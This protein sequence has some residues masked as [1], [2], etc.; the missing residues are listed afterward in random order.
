MEETAQLKQRKSRNVDSDSD[1]PLPVPIDCESDSDD[2]PPVPI[3]CEAKKKLILESKKVGMLERYV[4]YVVLK[5]LNHGRFDMLQQARRFSGLRHARF[6]DFK[7][8]VETKSDLPLK[9]WGDKCISATLNYER[10]VMR[11]PNRNPYVLYL[12]ST[13]QNNWLKQALC[14]SLGDW[15]IPVFSW[16]R[17]AAYSRPHL[18]VTEFE[19]GNSCSSCQDYHHNVDVLTPAQ[20]D[21][22]FKYTQKLLSVCVPRPGDLFELEILERKKDWRLYIKRARKIP[23]FGFWTFQIDADTCF[24]VNW[25]SYFALIIDQ[26]FG[27]VIR[28]IYQRGEMAFQDGVFSMESSYP[29]KTKT[30]FRI[31][32]AE[33]GRMTEFLRPTCRHWRYGAELVDEGELGKVELLEPIETQKRMAHKTFIWKREQRQK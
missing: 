6:S 23:T 19:F 26:K 22:A 32:T 16:F 15:T 7:V 9:F 12:P 13:H 14:L 28:Y 27:E 11:I 24:G 3:D 17:V 20:L 1:D 18:N 10:Y 33:T 25:E 4:S 30:S 2:P 31:N 29:E 8:L 21:S 5:K